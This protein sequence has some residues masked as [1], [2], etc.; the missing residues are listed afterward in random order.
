M[1]AS[2]MKKIKLEKG[3]EYWG[4][5]LS[6]QGSFLGDAVWARIIAVAEGMTGPSFYRCE[7][8]AQNHIAVNGGSGAEFIFCPF[9]PITMP[10]LTSG[11]R[12]PNPGTR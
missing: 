11:S 9:Q 5:V 2:V 3:R 8:M 6:G 12:K 1:L 10:S 4:I 7:S